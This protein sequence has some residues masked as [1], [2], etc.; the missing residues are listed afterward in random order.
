MDQPEPIPEH[1]PRKRLNLALAATLVAT[2]VTLDEAAKRVGA[3]NGASLRVCLHRA[4]VTA[5]QVRSL[6]TTAD[7]SQPLILSIVSQASEALRSEFSNILSNHTAQLK[8]IPARANLKHLKRVGE[9]IEPLARTAKIVHGW[10]DGAALAMIQAG[11]VPASPDDCGVEA[12]AN[13]GA[14]EVQSVTAPQE[15]EPAKDKP[16]TE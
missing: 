12:T 16:A 1:K 9:A 15:P 6:P 8:K 10:G 2:G 5:K 11:Q 7:R 4:G 14:I 13:S 3:A